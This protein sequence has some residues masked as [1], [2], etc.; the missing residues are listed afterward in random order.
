RRTLCG[1]SM[2]LLHKRRSVLAVAV[3]MIALSVA[4]AIG[5][6]E[7]MVCNMTAYKASANLSAVNVNDTLTI[8][9]TGDPDQEL[10]LSLVLTN[11]TPVMRELA[12]R[13]GEGAWATVASNLAPEFRVVSGVRRISNQQLVPLR[14]LGVKLTNDVIDRFRWDSFWDAPLDLES[15]V[16]RG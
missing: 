7:P 10:R 5:D 16:A 6:A 2:S 15:P 8:D 9:W 3:V 11:G 13:R 1:A 14:D 12:I 4:A